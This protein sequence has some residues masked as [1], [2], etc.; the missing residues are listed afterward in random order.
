M[1]NPPISN[2]FVAYNYKS[3]PTIRYVFRENIYKQLYQTCLILRTLY[4]LSVDK[5]H[6][7]IV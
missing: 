7:K 3:Y 6:A 5:S 2:C 1:L 4:Q